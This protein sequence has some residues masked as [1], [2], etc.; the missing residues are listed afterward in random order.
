MALQLQNFPSLIQNMAAAVQASAS[1]LLNLTAGSV[2]RAILEANAS[3]ALWLQWLIM[4]VLSMT[5][6]STSVTLDVDSWVADFGLARLPAVASSGVATFSRFSNTASAFVPV[7]AQV[8]TSDGTRIF[9]VN[10][11]AL[12][13][14]WNGSTGFTV[15][16][17]VTSVLLT[18]VDVTTNAAGVLSVGVAG[19]I[20]AG[21]LGLIASAISGIDTVTNAAPFVNGIDAESDTAL[22][23]RFANYV[24]TRSRATLP[25]VNYAISSVQQGLNWTI[26]ENV[27]G[28]AYQPGN[29]V[30]TV[31]DGTGAPTAGLI[32]QVG[33]AIA[34]Y[35]PI[36]STWTVQAPSVITVTVTMTI[37]TNPVANKT[38]LLATVQAAVLAYV[39]TLPDGAMLPYSRVAM[40]AYLVDPS[41]VDVTAVLVNAGTADIVPTTSQVLKATLGTVTIS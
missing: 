4:Q 2:L 33:A 20:Q 10:A 34:T 19:N 32:A 24:Q 11:D 28:G 25:A 31:D 27:L 13:A 6:L 22:R 30:V 17:G 18:V 14:A 23:A 8:K 9:Q 36:G 41:I 7:G 26:V 35:R 1:S 21:T 40:V 16:A 15:A 37:T 39:N 5:R 12:N 29:F 3:V 38:A